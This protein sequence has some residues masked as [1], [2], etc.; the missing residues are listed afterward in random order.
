MS[1]ILGQEDPLEEEIA[2]HSST[3]AWRIAWIEEPGGLHPWGRTCVRARAH[4]HTH[5]LLLMV[6]AAVMVGNTAVSHLRPY[7]IN[8]FVWI[9]SQS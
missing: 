7:L 2:T 5:T 9:P 6:E 4:T 1:S 8:E 3:L